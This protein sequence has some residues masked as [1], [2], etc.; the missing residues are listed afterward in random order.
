MFSVNLF[1]LG[2]PAISPFGNVILAARMVADGTALSYLRA[3][4]PTAQY[5]V[6]AHLDELEPGGTIM[7]WDRPA[8]WDALSGHKAWVGLCPRAWC[9][10]CG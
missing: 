10:S 1:G 9:S 2:R 7:L 6:C 8:L 5:K 3:A 4:C